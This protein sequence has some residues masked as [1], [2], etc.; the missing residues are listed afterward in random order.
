MSYLLD[1][2][3]C[4]A[5]L[6]GSPIVEGQ[7]VRHIGR[8]HISAV[9]VGEL[10][11]WVLRAEASPQRL[12]GLLDLLSDVTILPVDHSV[13]RRFGEVRAAL[14]DQGRPTPSMDL[15]IASTAWEYGL[16]LVTH[17]LQDFSHI[18]GLAVIDWLAP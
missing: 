12:Q 2:D 18:P 15:L 8:L 7:F 4:S 9:S 13:A 3:I 14:L 17:N 1:T 10:Y 5:Y 6:K 16:T 11:S